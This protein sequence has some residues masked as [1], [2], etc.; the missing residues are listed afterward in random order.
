MTSD[1]KSLV[2]IYT[3]AASITFFMLIAW[4]FYRNGWSWIQRFFIGYVGG[5]EAEETDVKFAGVEGMDAFIP[6]VKLS[7]MTDPILCADVSQIPEKYVPIPKGFFDVSDDPQGYSV[8][9]HE[10]F[11]SIDVHDDNSLKVRCGG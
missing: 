3:M 10:E 1:Q 7:Q 11:P 6:V 8:V 5:V 9:K 4:I 2:D